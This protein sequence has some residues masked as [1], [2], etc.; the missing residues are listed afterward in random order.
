[1]ALIAEAKI[2]IPRAQRSVLVGALVAAVRAKDERKSALA[3]EQHALAELSK[4]QLEEA[5]VEN[6]RLRGLLSASGL[7]GELP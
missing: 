2:K 5:V 1:M 3:R 7:F 4:L 6:L